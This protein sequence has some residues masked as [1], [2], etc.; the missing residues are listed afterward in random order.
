[1]MV[2]SHVCFE[3]PKTKNINAFVKLHKLWLTKNNRN[4]HSKF[5]KGQ[6]DFSCSSDAASI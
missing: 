4:K 6:H 1:M 5:C 3:F 2:K